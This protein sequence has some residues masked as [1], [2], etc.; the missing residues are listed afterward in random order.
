MD[1]VREGPGHGSGDEGHAHEDEVE[2][3]DGSE[4]AKPHATGVEPRGVGVRDGGCR[5][6]LH[7]AQRAAGRARDAQL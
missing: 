6:H 2:D 7:D 1:D 5:H 4:V 3:G